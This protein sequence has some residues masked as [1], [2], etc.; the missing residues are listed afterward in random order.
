MFQSYTANDIEPQF[1]WPFENTFYFILNLAVGGN[2][3]EY[4]DETTPFPTTLLVD[5]VRVYDLSEATF[6]QM[7]GTRLVHVNQTDEVYC[8]EGG[9]T[10]DTVSWTVPDGATFVDGPSTNCITV[11]FGSASGYV[12]A[13]AQSTACDAE[14]LSI[15]VEVQPF[16]GKE[17][18]F[19]TPGGTEDRAAFF[20]STGV[21]SETNG[22][23]EYTRNI[24]ELY[25][26]I[27]LKT[28]SITDPEL[29]VS[30]ERKFYMD[31]KSP[32][33]APCTRVL[34][35]LEDSSLTTAEDNYPTGRH[36]RYIAFMEKTDDWQRLEFD[37]YDRPQL[38]VSTVDRLVI[39]LDSFV[40]RAD[41]YSFR[42]L[43]SATKGCT[44]NCEALS[45]NACR[46]EAKSE[47]GA[48]TDG[49]NNDGFGFDGDGTIDCDDSDCWDDPACF[50]PGVS[51]PPSA[52]PIPAPSST[53]MP[54]LSP[55]AIA[56]DISFFPS[57]E[58]LVESSAPSMELGSDESLTPSL[59]FGPGEPL[60]PAFGFTSGAPPTSFWAGLLSLL[61]FVL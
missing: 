7:T 51:P 33:A 10:Y 17:F 20:A 31:I 27:Q 8:V 30:E 35:Q 22:T 61:L 5:Y 9:V 29:Y 2:W 32:T 23:V 38:G 59:E 25:D 11:N 12:Q 16:Y 15:P 37:F 56:D 48:C 1:S 19:L 47:A 57:V 18:S 42:N 34:I 26:H 24:T 52:V 43:D 49:V 14:T 45:T 6:G 54:T 50:S 53:V 60:V 36:S 40:E 13:V 28:S 3:P 46:K 39:L 55:S 41:S 21:Y 4:P 44:A 58:S